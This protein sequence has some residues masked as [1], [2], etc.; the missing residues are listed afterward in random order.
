MG[1]SCKTINQVALDLAQFKQKRRYFFAK[2]GR[3]REKA[4]VFLEVA[5]QLSHGRRRHTV[6][7]RAFAEE[8]RVSAATTCSLANR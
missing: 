7:R 8:M 1:N 4:A 2:Q 3:F 6:G 5:V